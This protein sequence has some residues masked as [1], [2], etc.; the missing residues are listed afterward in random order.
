[1]RAQFDVM[2]GVGQEGMAGFERFVQS[3]SGTL[4]RTAYL[5][6]GDRHLAEDLL[7][8]TLAKVAQH[9][10]AVEE[11]GNPEAYARTVLYHRAVD[12]W[13][14]RL[15]R[16]RVVGEPALEPTDGA[17]LSAE[18]ERRLLLQAALGRL[19]PKQRAVLV[20]RFY[21]DRT[22][23]QAAAVLGC[24]VS[25]VKT[26]TRDALKRLRVTAPEL[27]ELTDRLVVT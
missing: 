12:T 19:T 20:L 1:M 26:T 9:W 17:D 21:E 10:E 27:V 16:P 7:Q 2:G 8:D 4:L 6:S 14:M 22:E 11:E 18:S 15:R 5:L 3:R 23:A 13:R 24:S 25:T